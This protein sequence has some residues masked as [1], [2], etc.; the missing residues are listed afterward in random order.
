M[1]DARRQRLAVRT[2]EREFGG[3]GQARG[4][5]AGVGE[6]AFRAGVEVV[7]QDAVEPVEVVGE[8]QGFADAQVGQLLPPAVDGE[9]AQDA[10]V[11][12][13]V[14]AAL[15]DPA[16]VECRDVVPVF[17]VSAGRPR[18]GSRTRPLRKASRATVRVAVVVV[19]DAVEVVAPA[20]DAEVPAPVVGHPFVEEEARLLRPGDTV[21][22]VAG[23]RGQRGLGDV[24]VAPVMFGQDRHLAEADDDAGVQPAGVVE[25]EGHLALVVDLRRRHHAERGAHTRPRSCPG[26]GRT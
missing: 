7:V 4:G 9:P 1:K 17:P 21:W 2:Q 26:C 23:R 5:E 8:G 25:V 16:P 3:A 11:H 14:V 13:V 19:A 6:V 12:A 24:A 10:D 18:C 15:D 22:A 20:V